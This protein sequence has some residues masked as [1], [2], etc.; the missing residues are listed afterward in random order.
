VRQKKQKT[1]QNQKRPAR[2]FAG[3]FLFGVFNIYG[4][5]LAL[6]QWFR[7]GAYNDRRDRFQV[8]IEM[9][10]GQRSGEHYRMHD[11]KHFVKRIRKQTALTCSLA[12]LSALLLLP[13]LHHAVSAEDTKSKLVRYNLIDLGNVEA[14][15][16]ND[17]GQISGMLS[18]GKGKTRA[19]LHSGGKDS[20][21]MLDG[22][23]G[24]GR[25]LNNKGQVVGSIKG[26]KGELQAVTWKNFTLSVI[27]AKGQS[28]IASGINEGGQIVGWTDYP[29]G[30]QKAVLWEPGKP[31][32]S[33]H[34]PGYRASQ[35]IAINNRGQILA[36]AFRSDNFRQFPYIWKDG[37]TTTIS[38]MIRA[39]AIN[40]NG[41]VVGV[42]R[43]RD[44]GTRAA[45]WKNGRVRDI[46][47]RRDGSSEALSINNKG[48]IVGIR[49]IR[50]QDKILV[51][52]PFLYFQGHIR[53]LNSMIAP[54][55]D[56]WLGASINN[57]GQIIGV[58]IYKSKERSFLL[59]PI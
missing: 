24:V 2:I 4:S 50:L 51:T 47:G 43:T 16:I 36:A 8:R 58:G 19:F 48:E 3:R 1:R 25:S 13:V 41:Q 27:D 42:I 39:N 49:Y 29:N 32:R 37:K 30:P 23:N 26:A 5:F 15:A 38:S 14:G 40:D 21:R 12:C 45:L 6:R 22:A 17:I 57:R 46:D 7:Q 18:T 54:K 35:A 52:S 34:L 20:L 10:I 33:L 59:N 53:D 55:P 9:T 31:V 44:G 11:F 28:G 56:L